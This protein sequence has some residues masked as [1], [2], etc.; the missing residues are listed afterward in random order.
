MQRLALARAPPES[1]QRS[2]MMPMPTPM[3]TRSLR[4]GARRPANGPRLVA[5]E[6]RTHRR[7]RELCDEVLA[8]YRVATERDLFS[9]RERRDA[10]A[11]LA[12]LL[13]RDRA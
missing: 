7:L 1:H 11:L 8:S 13:P 9:E 6:R 2:Q 12:E 10:R 5:T 3:S 4:A